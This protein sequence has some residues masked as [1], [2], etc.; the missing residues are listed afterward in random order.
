MVPRHVYI[1]SQI[2]WSQGMYI[3]TAREVNTV[4]VFDQLVERMSWY[5]VYH[6]TEMIGFDEMLL[7]GGYYIYFLY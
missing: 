4:N 3:Y 1:H 6:L 7:L 2:Q 5:I